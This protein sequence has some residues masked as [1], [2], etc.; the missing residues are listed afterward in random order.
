MK[1][2]IE[3][4]ENEDQ[5][6]LNELEEIQGGTLACGYNTAGKYADEDNSDDVVF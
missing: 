6:N 4:Q 5:I 2:L 1:T 3:N